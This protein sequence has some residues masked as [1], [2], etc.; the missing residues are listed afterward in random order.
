MRP[1]LKTLH[2]LDLGTFWTFFD[3]FFQSLLG[4][5]KVADEGED[6]QLCDFLEGT[7]LKEQ[8]EDIKELGNLVSKLKR[9]GDGLGVHLIDKD[10][11]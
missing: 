10:L 8:V 9:A 7:Y 3:L 6:P 4:L 2:I 1:V 11:E 5:H